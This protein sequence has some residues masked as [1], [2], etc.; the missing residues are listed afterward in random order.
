MRKIACLVILVFILGSNC[1]NAETIPS[2]LP[3]WEQKFSGFFVEDMDERNNLYNSE[4]LGYYAPT[5]FTGY[6][7]GTIYADQGTAKIEDFVDFV[8]FYYE[9]RN[10]GQ[11]TYDD[12]D[13]YHVEGTEWVDGALE[14]YFNEIDGKIDEKSGTWKFTDTTKSFGFYAVKG[15]TEMAVYFVTPSSSEGKWTTQHLDPNNKNVV[16]DLSFLAGIDPPVTVVP[17]PNSLLLLGSS[18]LCLGFAFRRRRR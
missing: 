7:L 15:S 11:L 16:P 2:V 4:I 18:L 1:L 6:Y 17:E 10:W 3:L 5:E 13:F 12:S 8:E 9:V 14:V